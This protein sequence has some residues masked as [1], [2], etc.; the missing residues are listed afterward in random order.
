MLCRFKGCVM[1]GRLKYFASILVAIVIV[2]VYA[3]KSHDVNVLDKAHATVIENSAS[4]TSSEG[5]LAATTLRPEIK[6]LDA[7]S[8]KELIKSIQKNASSGTEIFTRIQIAS[9]CEPSV[10]RDVITQR[11]ASQNTILSF[12]ASFCVGYKGSIA[13][14][15]QKLLS[16]PAGDPYNQAYGM[17]SELFDEINKSHQDPNKVTVITKQLDAMLMA[18]NSQMETLVAAEALN[19]AGIIAPSTTEFAR[20]NGWQLSSE[21]L[22]QVQLL[23]VQ[24]KSCTNFGGCG[25]NQLLTMKI[26]SEQS[27]CAPGAT[28]DSIWR[29]VY[30]PSVY[31]VARKLS[32]SATEF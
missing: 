8:A 28:A 20:K 5:E 22:A 29:R 1:R 12:K 6:L 31:D 15:Q 7:S 18:R 14:E 2:V 9:A 24:M 26:C 13:L 3:R 11:S 32:A 17:A 4:A 27:T 21:E 25:I 30:A 10:G 19:Q 23:S 16:L